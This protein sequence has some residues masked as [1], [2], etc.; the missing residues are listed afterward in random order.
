V[1]LAGVSS[2]L[3]VMYSIS[4]NATCSRRFSVIDIADRMAS[5]FFACSAGMLPSKPICTH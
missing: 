3:G 4:L 2:A 1:L 5:N